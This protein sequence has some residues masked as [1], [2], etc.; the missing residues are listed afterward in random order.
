MEQLY[1][2]THNS[3]QPGNGCKGMFTRNVIQP[4]TEIRILYLYFVLENRILV[5]ICVQPI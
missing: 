4:V 2:T 1:I 3:E 5:Q